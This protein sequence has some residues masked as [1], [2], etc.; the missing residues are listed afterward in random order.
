MNRHEALELVHEFIKT[1]GL[2]NHML[3]V[4][5]AMRWYARKLNQDEEIWGLTGLLH[6][7]D[8][9]VHPIR[10]DHPNLGLS[11]LR[12]RGV[13]EEVIY[14]IASHADNPEYPRVSLLDKALY[15]CDEIT[16]MI[17]AVALVR[18]SRSLYDLEATS[19]KK[20]WKDKSF[21]AGALRPVMESGAEEFGMPLWEHVQNVIHAM[22]AIAPELGLAGDLEPTA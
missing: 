14:S 22:R 10:G 2:I 17:T 18:P 21:A 16:G 19:V 7:Y 6:D 15:A 12:D 3:S 5:A 13:S 9:E 1:E 11:L 8:W 20:K 4:E